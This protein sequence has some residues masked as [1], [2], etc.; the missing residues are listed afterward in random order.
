MATK[1]IRERF[2]STSLKFYKSKRLSD[3]WNAHEA[4]GETAA[5]ESRSTTGGS[6]VSNPGQQAAAANS[7]PALLL[8]TANPALH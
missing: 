6:W 7:Y 2:S 8:E 5:Q 4:A 3:C 1:R